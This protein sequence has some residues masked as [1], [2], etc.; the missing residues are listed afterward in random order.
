MYKA[1]FWDYAI[2]SVLLAVVMTTLAS[3]GIWMCTLGAVSMTGMEMLVCLI[4]GSAWFELW[5]P[6]CC[7]DEVNDILNS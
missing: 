1:K 7:E 4:G 2:L 6:M 3:I 5:L